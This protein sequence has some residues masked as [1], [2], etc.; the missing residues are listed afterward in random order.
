[1]ENAIQNL[2]SNLRINRGKPWGIS[3][4]IAADLNGYTLR[5]VL[6]ASEFDQGAAWLVLDNAAA[7]GVTMTVAAGVT[8]YAILVTEQQT[9]SIPS[10]AKI[11]YYWLTAI[12]PADTGSGFLINGAVGVRTPR[13]SATGAL[14]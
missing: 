12:P 4:T 7:G 13:T 10:A 3:G 11:G 2:P 6:A 5:L 1:M 8:S 9:L 14:P